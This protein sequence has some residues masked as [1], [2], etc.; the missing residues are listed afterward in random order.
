MVKVGGK[1]GLIDKNGKYLVNPQYAELG[2]NIAC[3]RIWFANDE[4]KIGFLDG[5]GKE[6]I[7]AQFDYLY[8]GKYISFSRGFYSDGYAIVR[9]GDKFGIIDKDG[10]YLVNPQFDGISNWDA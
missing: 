1:Y 3:N 7:S 2:T 4:G 6:V 10:K 9:L 5:T 8:S